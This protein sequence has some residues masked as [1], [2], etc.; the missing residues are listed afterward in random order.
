MDYDLIWFKMLRFRKGIV[1][2]RKLNGRRSR[3]EKRSGE[4]SAENKL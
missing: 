4:K 3:I 1:R 2:Y